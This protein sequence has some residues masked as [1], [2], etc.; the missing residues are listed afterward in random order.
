MPL[1]ILIVFGTIYYLVYCIKSI[2]CNILSYSH[3]LEFAVSQFVNVSIKQ[4]HV[5]ID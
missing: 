2:V 3:K 5:L 1:Y 4:F